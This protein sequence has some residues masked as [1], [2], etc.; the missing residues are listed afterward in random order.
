MKRVSVSIIFN[1]NYNDRWH[2]E[3]RFI[4]I[5]SE[6]LLRIFLINTVTGTRK[7]SEESKDRKR[8]SFLFK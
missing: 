4:E 8:F 3:E 5:E 1:S 6:A 7:L 2:V